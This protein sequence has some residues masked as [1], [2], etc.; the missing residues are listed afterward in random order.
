MARQL[1][2]KVVFAG[3]TYSEPGKPKGSLQMLF[4]SSI[5]LNLQ[6]HVEDI[7]D[8][9]QPFHKSELNVSMRQHS[10]QLMKFILLT[11]KYIYI[12]FYC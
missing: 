9:D 1:S 10:L 2:R 4:K 3:G 12:F 7:S 5:S 11:Q 8:V 6:T